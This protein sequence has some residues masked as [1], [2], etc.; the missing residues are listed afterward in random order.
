MDLHI[1]TS[2]SPCADKTMTPK[3]IVREAKRKGLDAIGICDHNSA[4]NVISVRKASQQE[5]LKVI[6][7][8]EVTSREEVHFVL[9]FDEDE[10]LFEMQK[11]VYENLHGVNTPEVFGEQL[12]INE[13][14]EIVSKNDKLLIGATELSSEDIVNI[15]HG[16]EGIAIAA[17]IDRE[18]FGIIG[19]LGFIPS[20]LKLD[21]VE[22]SPRISL[23]E[24]KKNFNI[25][26]YPA[27]T[28]SDAHYLE[29]IGKSYNTFLIKEVNIKEIKKA[30]LGGEGRCIEV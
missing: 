6:G 8:M 20:E 30:F 4:G 5:N 13:K 3:N 9:L 14:D 16:L 19:K 11:I 25:E 24:A 17:H 21:A 10:N 22:I 26:S 7:G 18:G 23:E 12:V 29:D 28:S 1:H 27:I 15:T 2:L